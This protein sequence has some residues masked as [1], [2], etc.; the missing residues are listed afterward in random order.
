M[1]FGT[2]VYT[3]KYVHYIQTHARFD[4]TSPLKSINNSITV[5]V[6]K[7]SYIT[8]ATASVDNVSEDDSW[9]IIEKNTKITPPPEKNCT[10]FASSET[11]Q[12]YY[13]TSYSSRQNYCIASSR[14]LHLQQ[15][16]DANT[17][18]GNLPTNLASSTITNA[19]MRI[20]RVIE[21]QPRT[22]ILQK[23]SRKPIH[24]RV[25][26]GHETAAE[27]HACYFNVQ[28]RQFY[29]TQAN[30]SECVYRKSAARTATV[31]LERTR[32]DAET[33]NHLY[34]S[35]INFSYKNWTAA[36]VRYIMDEQKQ[37]PG[38]Q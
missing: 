37:T 29:P 4:R 33:I 19:V 12:N 36:G 8:Y 31:T 23:I 13:Q 17:E 20:C 38:V 35:S 2:N 26:G 24:S 21:T 32:S 28:W 5:L 1:Y 11:K 15:R 10:A 14:C 27:T 25:N 22:Y 30:C 9:N 16:T 3:A 6:K 7:L 18:Y 34:W